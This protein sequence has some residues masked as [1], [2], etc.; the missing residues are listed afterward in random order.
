MFCP[1]LTR[2]VGHGLPYD[3]FCG[4]LQITSVTMPPLPWRS[5]KLHWGLGITSGV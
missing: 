5:V 1:L 3:L 2:V 4:F